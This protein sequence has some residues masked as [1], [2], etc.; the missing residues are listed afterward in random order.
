[1]QRVRDLGKL[2]PKWD[3]II[4]LQVSGSYAEE[5]EADSNRQRG[6]RTRRKQCLP[7]TT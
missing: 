6:W 1:V 7:D 4:K 5:E 2:S 3:D